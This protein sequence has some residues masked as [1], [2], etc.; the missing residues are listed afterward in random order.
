MWSIRFHRFEYWTSRRWS[1]RYVQ[2]RRY[3]HE[4]PW[5]LIYVFVLRWW[6]LVKQINF[7]CWW[8][9]I[10]SHH[11]SS[12]ISDLISS[13]ILR[14]VCCKILI[15][16]CNLCRVPVQG[17]SSLLTNLSLRRSIVS[18][19]QSY[20]P[21]DCEQELCHLSGQRLTSQNWGFSLELCACG[22][23]NAR[24]Q[25][26]CSKASEVLSLQRILPSRPKRKI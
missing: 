4:V 11:I 15:L 6:S 13:S 17:S 1:R 22:C 25:R 21:L 2:A 9:V 18:F 23:R 20:H 8:C 24:R 12:F 3:K 10:K 7:Y 19:Y 26:K 5:C 16:S 14:L